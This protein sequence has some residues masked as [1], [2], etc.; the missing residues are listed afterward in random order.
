MKIEVM[1]AELVRCINIVLKAV[2][3][4]TT[5]TIQECIL[6]CAQ[7][8]TITFTTN[9]MELGIETVVNGS[10]AERGIV[11]IDAK[12]FSDIIRKLPDNLVSIETD[13]NMMTTIVC[14]KAKFRIPS[15]EGDDFSG[16]PVI[17]NENPVVVS[18]MTLRDMVLRTIFSISQNDSNKIMTGEY[19]EIHEN[20]MRLIALDGHRIA[21][22]K[23]LLKEVYP[24]MNAIIPGKTLSDIAKILTGESEKEVGIYLEKNLIMFR[25]DETTV[26]SRLI[27][28]NYFNV[29]RMLPTDYQTKVTI[30]RREMADCIDRSILMIREDDR[31][32]IIMNIENDQMQLMV[33]SQIGSMD[34]TIEIEAEG[35]DV[36]IGFNPK[37]I[38]DALRAIDEEKIEIYYMNSKAPCVIKDEAGS[39]IYL[40]LP[41]NFIS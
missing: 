41:V 14:E 12:L 18:Q 38:N 16:I 37:L 27:E 13:S 39:Y 33:N 15:S 24:D 31:K 25:F 26:V 23:T 19:M 21:I 29:D 20:S 6:I 1:K 40:V 7:A 34:E 8:G 17:E 4:K 22:R 35:K 3:S 9:D 10:V 11:A 30:N 5:L 28:G 36:K 2:P 32:P